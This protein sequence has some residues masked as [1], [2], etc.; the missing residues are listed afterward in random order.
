MGRPGF[1]KAGARSRG[2]EEPTSGAGAER[3]RAMT[4]CSP[5]AKLSAAHGHR[6]AKHRGVWG[7]T[8]TPPQPERKS[9]R[10]TTSGRNKGATPKRRRTRRARGE[11]AG[12]VGRLPSPPHQ[13]TFILAWCCFLSSRS[14]A[15]VGA[16]IGAPEQE[17]VLLCCVLLL[18]CWICLGFILAWCCFLSSRSQT[19]VGATIGAPEQ[20]RV[21]E[22]SFHQVIEDI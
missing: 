20:E 18:L 21:C 16:T 12:G 5:L 9:Q 4:A 15:C 10:L 3:T 17:R 6:A 8:A 13:R 2:A 22:L 14:Q 19:C 1:Q 7:R 11:R